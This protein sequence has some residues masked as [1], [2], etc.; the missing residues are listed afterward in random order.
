MADALSITA[1]ARRQERKK[2]LPASIIAVTQR[3]DRRRHT[4]PIPL[5]N[6]SARDEAPS[7]M[8]TT[9]LTAAVKPREERPFTDF[10]PLLDADRP[11]PVLVWPA[12]TERQDVGNR[13]LF[14]SISHHVINT[15]VQRHRSSRSRLHQP[16]S[17]Q[18]DD[19]DAAA[20]AVVDAQFIEDDDLLRGGVLVLKGDMDKLPKCEFSRIPTAQQ[21]QY[22]TQ[23]N[24]DY[25]SGHYLRYTEPA[26]DELFDRV[27][28]D[29]DEQG[30][31]FVLIFFFISHPDRFLLADRS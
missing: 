6:N 13:S 9:P 14:S 12:P 2:S 26:E 16:Q 8:L 24:F 3:K 27:E 20:A 19:N 5:T 10:F 18:V 30:I 23:V 15:V 7:P 31:Y 22:G 4:L 11:L 17:D 21:I 1:D 28:Y 29:M 25:P